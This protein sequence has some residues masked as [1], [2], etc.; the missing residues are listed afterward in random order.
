M[1]DQATVDVDGTSVSFRQ[2][3]VEGPPVV[4]VHGN[5]DAF[6]GV[7]AVPRALRRAVRRV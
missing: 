3:D 7:A 4:F 1:V 6:R 5:P 2:R